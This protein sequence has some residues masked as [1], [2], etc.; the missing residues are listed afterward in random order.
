MR[1]A[2]P[3]P[4]GGGVGWGPREVARGRGKGGARWAGAPAHFPARA[5]RKAGGWRGSDWAWGPRG[6]K[7]RGTDSG[8]EARAGRRRPGRHHGGRGRPE[9][10][11]GQG[12]LNFPCLEGAPTPEPARHPEVPSPPDGPTHLASPQPCAPSTRA[13]PPRAPTSADARHPPHLHATPRP[14]PRGP[15]SPPG[16]PKPLTSRRPG[17]GLWAV[18][19]PNRLWAPRRAAA[20]SSWA[21]G[22]ASQPQ[23]RGDGG[24]DQGGGRRIPG[25]AHPSGV[26]AA[27]RPGAQKPSATA[28][29]NLTGGETEAQGGAQPERQLRGVHTCPP[30]RE[31]PLHPSSGR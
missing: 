26:G 29:R 18:D 31:R 3:G 21:G 28:P 5:T 7:Q 23:P 22:G 14:L 1:T 6:P 30:R 25:P 12:A 20:T 10:A 2:N 11:G 8:V 4:R 13:P 9:G 19:A 16:V 15:P 24:G 27:R 17:R